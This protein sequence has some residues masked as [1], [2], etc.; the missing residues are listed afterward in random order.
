MTAADSV[1]AS[2]IPVVHGSAVG[3]RPVHRIICESLQHLR[4]ARPLRTHRR[5]RFVID[6]AEEITGAL[7]FAADVA[8]HRPDLVD[9]L[10]EGFFQVAFHPLSRTLDV[11]IGPG[12]GTHDSRET[13]GPEDHQSRNEQEHQL[14]ARQI[15]HGSS[16]GVGRTTGPGSILPPVQQIL[17]SL[18]EWP[19]VF[20]HRGARAHAPENTL[21]AFALAERLGA[22]GIET[23]AWLTADGVVVLDHDGTVRRGLRKIPISTVTRGELPGSVPSLAELL[24]RLSP[25]MELSI[26]VKNPAAADQ[27][28]A[29][30]DASGFP[31]RRLWLCHPEIDVVTSWRRL[32][33]VRLVDSTRVQKIAEGVERRCARLS[34]SGIDALNMPQQDWTGG[35]TTLVHRFGVLA[36][37]WDAQ[38]DHRVESLLRMGIDGIFGD[39][40]D[41]MVENYRRHTGDVPPRPAG[42]AEPNG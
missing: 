9:R 38:Q 21:Q 34:E 29:V 11:G 36:L 41:R 18:L 2:R 15:E 33:E 8:R 37:A 28:V 3:R 1:I 19:I 25:G 27:I 35:L 20:A 24:E 17:P 23:D 13:I 30:C 31:R 12:H 4:T 26:D 40:V 22:N 10:G 7:E 14:A 42:I 5:R 16:I 39:H 6:R 32:D